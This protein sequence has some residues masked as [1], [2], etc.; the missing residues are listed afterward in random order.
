MRY[1]PKHWG[2]VA[3]LMRDSTYSVLEAV[4]EKPKGWKEL[5]ESTQNY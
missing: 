1:A 5:K 3:I 2:S 4:I